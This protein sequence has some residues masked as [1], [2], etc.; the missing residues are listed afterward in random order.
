MS[1]TNTT[2]NLE[3]LVCARWSLEQLLGVEEKIRIHGPISFHDVHQV[4][5]NLKSIIELAGGEH[6]D[7][8][9]AERKAAASKV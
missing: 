2:R 4:T 7:T 1:K 9:I 5:N 3:I 8:P 6:Y